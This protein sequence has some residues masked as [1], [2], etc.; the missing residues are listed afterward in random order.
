MVNVTGQYTGATSSG[1]FGM[2]G[3]LRN[4]SRFIRGDQGTSKSSRRNQSHVLQVYQWGRSKTQGRKK[5]AKGALLVMPSKKRRTKDD[6]DAEP[7]MKNSI[8]SPEEWYNT[9]MQRYENLIKIA[10]DDLPGLW[11]SWEEFELSI[12]KILNIRDCTLPFAGIALG[13]PVR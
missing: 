13:V 2:K 12:Q 1:V 8:V 10:N 5:E 4:E 3:E 9:L 6:A 11:D 7:V